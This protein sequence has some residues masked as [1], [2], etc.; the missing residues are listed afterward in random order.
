MRFVTLINSEENLKSY[1]EKILLDRD[2]K[3]KEINIRG[4]LITSQQTP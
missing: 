3:N 2:L 1:A 4:F